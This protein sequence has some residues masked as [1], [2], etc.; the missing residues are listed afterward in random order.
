MFLLSLLREFDVEICSRRA[1]TLAQK[2]TCERTLEGHAGQT[3]QH[4]TECL[5]VVVLRVIIAA[6]EVAEDV[7][8]IVEDQ[9][10]TTNAC[11]GNSMMR[12]DGIFFGKTLVKTAQKV[13]RNGLSCED[14]VRL[15]VSVR[16]GVC[17][18]NFQCPQREFG[19]LDI[20][21]V[22]VKRDG[23]LHDDAAADDDVETFR[24]RS[25]SKSESPDNANTTSLTQ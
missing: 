19:V 24:T 16:C 17:L 23:G 6:A 22:H 2:T 20:V 8:E 10:Q 21:L 13:S 9:E 5:V 11:G 7:E 25:S 15:H 18:L 14:I 1:A 3:V 12:R 4:A